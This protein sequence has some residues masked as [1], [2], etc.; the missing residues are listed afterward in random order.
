MSEEIEMFVPVRSN[1][2]TLKLRLVECSH[3]H[4]QLAAVSSRKPRQDHERTVHPQLQRQQSTV[5]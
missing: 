5:L 1:G 2:R 4:Q 3:P